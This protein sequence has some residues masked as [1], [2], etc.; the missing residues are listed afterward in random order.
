MQRRSPVVRVLVRFSWSAEYGSHWLF[1]S[2]GR[3]RAA[4]ESA[5]RTRP[6]EVQWSYLGLSEQVALERPL[7]D[8]FYLSRNATTASGR[9]GSLGAVRLQGFVAHHSS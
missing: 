1:R 3:G 6:L 5:T 4:R 7:D 8:S 9:S 2:G